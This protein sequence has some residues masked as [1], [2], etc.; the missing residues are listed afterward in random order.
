MCV[1]NIEGQHVLRGSSELANGPLSLKDPCAPHHLSL[2]DF[3]DR[4][5][6][7]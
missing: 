5:D 4:I 1:K 6:I 2:I 3:S 7:S